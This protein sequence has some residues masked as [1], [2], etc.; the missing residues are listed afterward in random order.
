MV[1]K[2]GA[3]E[4]LSD[5]AIYESVPSAGESLRRLGEEAARFLSDLR[6]IAASDGCASKS[7]CVKTVWQ[8]LSCALCRDNALVYDRSLLAL[9]RGVGKD[10]MPGLERALDE[11]GDVWFRSVLLL[12]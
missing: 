12:M 1:C 10:F 8:E 11:A 7:A 5:G 6:E 3:F 4:F 9:A 2:S